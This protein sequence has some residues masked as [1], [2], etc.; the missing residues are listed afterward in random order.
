MAISSYATL[1]SAV[2]EWLARDQD[3]VLIN[4][5]P[6]FITLCEAKLNRMLF[7]PQMEKRSTTTIDISTDEPEFISLPSDFQTMRRITLA[8][9]DSRK[10]KLIFKGGPEF[11]DYRECNQN[12]S[13]RSKYFT[14][15]GNEIELAATPDADYT[16]EMVYRAN[17]TPLNVDN[18]SNWLLQQAP[19]LYLYGALMEASPYIG[20]DERIQV[21]AAGF[22]MA[23]S[24]LNNLGPRQTADVGA[25][26]VMLPGPTP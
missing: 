24:D 25:S 17:L 22:S 23:L 7:V 14:L 12:V 18:A 11:D 1:V 15:V 20:K 4:R 26:K 3:A 5:I 16:I 2:T 10:T 21:W 13:G 19:D 8:G 9:T 6:D